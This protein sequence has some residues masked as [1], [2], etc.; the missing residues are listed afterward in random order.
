MDRNHK[1]HSLYFLLPLVL[2][3]LAAQA[4][5]PEFVI[6]DVETSHRV[7]Y[8]L[9]NPDPAKFASSETPDSV[10]VPRIGFPTQPG[11]LA[12]KRLAYRC[13]P[14]ALHSSHWVSS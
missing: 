4:Q 1:M 3:G 9:D 12:Q 10:S 14:K 6:L 13:F 8:V 5:T 2:F 11:Q 7:D